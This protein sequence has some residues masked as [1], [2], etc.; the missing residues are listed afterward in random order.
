MNASTL[1]NS[2]ETSTP[3]ET[4]QVA[5]LATQFLQAWAAGENPAPEH[6]LERLSKDADR[7]AFKQSVA[8][9]KMLRQVLA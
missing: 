7:D 3:A 4:G 9:G 5:H 6:Y 1:A 8:M 2:S